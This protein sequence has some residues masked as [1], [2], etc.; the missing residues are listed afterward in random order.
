[1]SNEPNPSREPTSPPLSEAALS[2]ICIVAAAAISLVF[3]LNYLGAVFAGP[4]GIFL[5]AGWRKK[6]FSFRARRSGAVAVFQRSTSPAA[7]WCIAALCLICF[8]VGLAIIFDQRM[9]RGVR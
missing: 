5:W 6:E 1:M 4:A 9:H 7:Y 3:G 8:A 2:G